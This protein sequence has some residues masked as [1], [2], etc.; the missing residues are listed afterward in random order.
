MLHPAHLPA[1][2][3]LCR[4]S[5]VEGRAADKVMADILKADPAAVAA[6]EPASL[7]LATI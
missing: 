1:L 7:P 4:L 5:L 2:H 3:E 6:T